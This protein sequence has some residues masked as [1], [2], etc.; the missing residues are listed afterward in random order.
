MRALGHPCYGLLCD[1]C[2][3]RSAIPAIVG[4]WFGWHIG[5]HGLYLREM[6]EDYGYMEIPS[7]VLL[8]RKFKR[9]IWTV[10]GTASGAAIGATFSWRLHGN[11]LS[12]IRS[13]QPLK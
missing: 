9:V 2:N 10:I 7:A 13:G 1:P 3:C 8:R 5:T 12:Q 6:G 4:G 11:P